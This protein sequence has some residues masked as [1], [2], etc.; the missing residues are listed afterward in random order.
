MGWN[1]PWPVPAPPQPRPGT[2]VPRVRGSSRGTPR[3]A[4]WEARF[5]VTLAWAPPGPQPD[6]CFAQ[7]A[8]TA[9][10]TGS[11]AWPSHVLFSRGGEK[12]PCKV[13][14]RVVVF[15]KQTEIFPEREAEFKKRRGRETC[16]QK[17]E[18]KHIRGAKNPKERP[19]REA[20][21]RETP[22]WE[23]IR[24]SQPSGRRGASA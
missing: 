22:M 15:F 20:S 6:P 19:G 24:S 23:S 18:E 1:V 5:Q 9:F 12:N 4:L 10:H 11:S 7:K 16:R 2:P 14:H 21:G 17:R 3:A 13:R 8:H